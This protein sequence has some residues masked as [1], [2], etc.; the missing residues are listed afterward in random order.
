MASMELGG[1]SV[2]ES[3]LAWKF[4]RASG[5]GGQN[6]NKVSTAVECRLDLAMA[7]LPPGVRARLEEL[8]GNRL[9]ARGEVVVF[10]DV[11]RT[12]GRNRTE[13][14]ARLDALVAASRHAPKPRVA[15][16]PS[17]AQ[18]AKRRENKKRRG[19]VKR[20]RRPPSD[21]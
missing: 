19:E 2:P 4:V 14:L 21:Y 13:A 10:A 3:A 8:A 6:V 20:G 16:R 18:K 12:Q 15:T 17:V 5:P 1:L 9:N 7:D 11:H